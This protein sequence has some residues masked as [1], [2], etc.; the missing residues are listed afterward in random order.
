MTGIH[1][2]CIVVHMSTSQTTKSQVRRDFSYVRHLMRLADEAMRNGISD[3]SESGDA[4]QIAIELHAA[5]GTFVRYLDD[6]RD[7]QEDAA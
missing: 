4:Y 5:A 1:G 2:V 3:V 6:L 7:A